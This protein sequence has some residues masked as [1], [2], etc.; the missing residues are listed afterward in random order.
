MWVR[1]PPGAPKT[2]EM[3]CMQDTPSNKEAEKKVHDLLVK[4]GYLND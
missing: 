1:V 2:K 3:A 4:G